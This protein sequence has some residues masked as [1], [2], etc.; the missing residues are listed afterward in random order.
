MQARVIVKAVI[1][2]HNMKRAL[3]IRRRPDDFEGWEGA[4]GAV[5][6][7]ETMEEA[8]IREVSEETGLQVVPERILYASLDEVC[9]KKM[10][11]IVYLCS[12]TEETIVLSGEHTDY[13]WVDKA[14]CEAMLQ[15]GIATDFKKHGVYELEW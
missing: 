2:N 10:I 14:E 11:F 12:T 4:G 9:G 6:E 15:G 1:L 13:R 7:G 3:L 8:I 5:E